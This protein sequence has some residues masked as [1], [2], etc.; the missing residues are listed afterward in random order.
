MWLLI[1]YGVGHLLCKYLYIY[2]L[3]CF[4]LFC[5]VLFNVNFKMVIDILFLFIGKKHESYASVRHSKEE[6][7]KK[8]LDVH[9]LL[10]PKY[11][12]ISLDLAMMVQL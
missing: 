11:Y 3:F 10:P 9:L 5:F 2:I 4:V 6:I 1:S 7:C 12:T 8:L